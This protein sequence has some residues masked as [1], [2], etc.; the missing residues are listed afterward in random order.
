[1]R[2]T[3]LAAAL[4]A[5][6]LSLP[7]LAQ[8]EASDT[9]DAA[10]AAIG[11]TALEEIVVTGEKAD[12]SVQD[13]ATS[14]AVTTE[15]RME[16]ET[17]TN[18]YQVLDR[19]ANV[20]KTYGDS[21]FTLRGILSNDG[22]GAPLSTIYLDG[23][24]M[25]HFMTATAPT[26]LWDLSQVEILRGP[27]STI[28]GENALAGAVILRSQDPSLDYWDGRA[29]L[30]WSDPSDR[31]VAFAS[32]G[33]LVQDELGVRI[34]LEERDF[35]G[36]VDNPTRGV[37]ED[38]ADSRLLR[39]KM[40]WTPAAVPGLT[41]RL[42]FT[43]FD[44]NGP[45]SFVY[46]NLDVEDYFDNRVNFS[47]APNVDDTLTNTA[48]HELEYE[49]SERWALS[50]VTAWSD[51]ESERSY[52]N[53]YSPDPG[54]FGGSQLDTDAISQELRASFQGDRLRGL[55]GLYYSTR[56]TD[57][58]TQSLTNVDTPGDTIAAVLAGNGIDAATAAY[59]AGLYVR[60]LP[61]IEVDYRSTG[62]SE[63]TNKAFFTDFE[64]DLSDRYALLGGFRYDR[65]SY[66]YGSDTTAA[67][68][69][70]LPD[71]AAFGAQLAPAIAGIN[72]AVLGFVADASGTTPY[73]TRT[74][75]NFLPKIGLRYDASDDVSLNFV[76]QRGYRS[77]GSS[78]NIAR[79]LVVPYDPE[80]TDNYELSLRSQW[81]DGKLTLNANA[82]YIDWKDK[83]VS[84][85]FGNGNFDAHTVNAGRAHLSGFELE[86]T[87]YVSDGFDWY[88]S[89]GHTRTRFDE[90][91]PVLGADIYDYSGSEFAYAPRWTS[92]V[93][94]N[95]R[96]AEHWV[97]N[98]NANHRTSIYSDVGEFQVRESGR[99]L[100]NGR[101]GYEADAWSVW[102]YAE[103]L[104][105]ETYVMYRYT[106]PGLGLTNGILGAPRVVG[107][108]LELQW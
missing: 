71:P 88:A 72:R 20:S 103:N 24:P 83:Q 26:T 89:L 76:A 21:G 7:V 30:L 56:D 16:Q 67:F 44:R 84:A 68:V 81:L 97:A 28:Q 37:G 36:F 57:N 19:T 5:S 105:D 77:G 3:C 35:D 48:T 39:A 10:A 18:L 82:F 108:G 94:G 106:D 17:L 104:F 25:S 63:S 34:A 23:A 42:G 70:T 41:S 65:Q 99:T 93:G 95:W 22:E 49:V 50:S 46:A 54:S 60:A 14:V 100:V 9:A 27:Q 96:F 62:P 107:V 52:D 78:F 75:S 51:A 38:A 11:E 74:F 29:R 1:M 8:D 40:L 43:H 101:F 59:I 2:L 64:L 86:A 102:L 13:T 98:L 4:S 58:A 61:V 6:L 31:R 87:H 69:G 45:Y 80:Y 85:N 53:D 32:G 55:M 73:S 66:G 79:S 90:F 92:A 91:R 12:R 15:V 47:D 33:P